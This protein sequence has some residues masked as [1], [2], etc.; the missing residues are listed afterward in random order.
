MR[1]P[2]EALDSQRILA[3]CGAAV[4]SGL[5]YLVARHLETGED[6]SEY[7]RA[8]WSDYMKW[9]G[10]AP[11]EV[12]HQRLHASHYSFL[13]P[14]EARFITAD[15]VRATCLVGVPEELVEQV[16]ALGRQGLRQV[17]LYPPL[18]RQYRVIEDFADRVMAR[19]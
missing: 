17:M 2:D 6:P 5:H 11:P 18:N 7:A 10:Q 13:D 16:R 14:E 19:V 12:R 15:L 8:V 3:E 1:E 9:L 4:L